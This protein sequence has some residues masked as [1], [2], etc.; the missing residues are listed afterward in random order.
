M[1]R[2]IAGVVALTLGLA[3]TACGDDDDSSSSSD[4]SVD[5]AIG[6][7]EKTDLTIALSAPN[8]DSQAPVRIAIDKGYYKDEGLTVKVIDAD[9]IRE[10]IIGGSL[11]LGVENTVDIIGAAAAGTDLRIVA[12]YRQREPYIIAASKDVAKPSD[13]DGKQVILGD[14]PGTPIIEVRLKELANASFDLTDVDYKAVYPPGFSDAWVENFVSGQVDATVIFPRHRPIIEKAGGH[15]ILDEIKE[16]PN[17]S[18]A[19]TTDWIAENPNTL[20]R[21]LRATMKGLAIYEDPSQQKYVQTMMEGEGFEI[22]DG[23]RQTEIYAFG[24]E[25]YDPDMGMKQDSFE[26]ALNAFG[27]KVPD[28]DSYTDTVNLERAQSA[29]D[30]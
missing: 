10:G 28:W 7:P 16:W 15:F 13:L 24:P 30:E 1:K 3:L 12:G 18:V 11:D 6:D 23:E 2:G 22:S 4:V 27:A 29:L 9:N 17:D 20:A 14:A 21:F 19:A 8:V 25:L 26:E 5:T